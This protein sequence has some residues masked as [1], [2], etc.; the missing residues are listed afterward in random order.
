MLTVSSFLFI[1]VLDASLIEVLYFYSR[2][3]NDAWPDVMTCLFLPFLS[4]SRIWSI[5]LMFSSLGD[6]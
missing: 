2:F 4:M 5:E 6:S 1:S 3:G